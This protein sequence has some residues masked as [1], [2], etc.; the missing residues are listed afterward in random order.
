MPILTVIQD[1]FVQPT[2]DSVVFTQTNTV[3][4]QRRRGGCRRSRRRRRRRRGGR[5]HCGPHHCLHFLFQKIRL[6]CRGCHR[7]FCR[8]IGCW[9]VVLLK[10]VVPIRKASVGV[11]S[12]AP[13]RGHRTGQHG[14][15]LQMS[16]FQDQRP[17]LFEQTTPNGMCVPVKKEINRNQQKSTEINKNQQKSTERMST[18]QQATC[19]SRHT[20]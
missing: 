5:P 9:W 19:C 10:H 17:N 4:Q 3:Q 14:R 7:G 8:C 6:F 2:Y 12:P 20:L 13:I 11:V 1:Q 16:F 15:H 18:L